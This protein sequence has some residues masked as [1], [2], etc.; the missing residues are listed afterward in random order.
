MLRFFYEPNKEIIKTAKKNYPNAS[1]HRYAPSHSQNLGDKACISSV[2][3]VCAS[4]PV[5][6]KT[7]K[8]RKLFNIVF[9]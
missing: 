1:K 2:D 3:N 6:I 5:V 8:F 4:L 9:V 7:Y